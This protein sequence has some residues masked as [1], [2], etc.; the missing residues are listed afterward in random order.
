MCVCVCVC[1]PSQ[2]PLLEISTEF[3]L[4]FVI[5]GWTVDPGEDRE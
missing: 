1:Q 3:G 2:G 5:Q 4:G